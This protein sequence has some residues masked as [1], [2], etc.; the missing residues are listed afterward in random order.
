MIRKNNI[1]KKIL[2]FSIIDLEIYI[3]Y[4]IIILKSENN[5]YCD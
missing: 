4:K 1:L 3:Y 5:I 2:K